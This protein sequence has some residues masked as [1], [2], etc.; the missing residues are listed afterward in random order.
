MTYAESLASIGAAA[1]AEVAS[2]TAS[3]ADMRTQTAALVAANVDLRAAIATLEARIAELTAPPVVTPPP[4]PTGDRLSWAPPVLTSPATIIP[5]DNVGK[6]VLTAGRDYV[7]KLPT[8]RAWKNSRGLHIEGGRNVVV[9][10]GL[11]DVG[12]GYYSGGT[13]P[14]VMADGYVKRA[15]YVLNA[16]GTVHI[17]GVAFTSSTGT[18]S[19][20]VNFSAPYARAQVQNVRLLVPLVGSKAYNHADALQSWNGPKWLGVDGFTATTGYQGMFLNAH[21]TGSSP[22]DE[23]WV[24]RRV[25]LNGTAAAKYILW[26]IAPPTSLATDRVF[27]SGGLGNYPN[28]SAWPGVVHSSQPAGKGYAATAGLGYVSPG[29]AA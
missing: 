16:T 1:D 26:K 2:L 13:G 27:T 10:G 28:S 14:G 19:E 6:I 20:G 23:G 22:V 24:L 11:V 7:I 25:E 8:D 9:I 21:D 5:G 15:A 3:L 4:A 18:L 29:Y 12:A 17:E